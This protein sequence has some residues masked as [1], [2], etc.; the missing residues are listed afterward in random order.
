MGFPQGID[1]IPDGIHDIEKKAFFI[2]MISNFKKI[3]VIV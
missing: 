2:K 3:K 1:R